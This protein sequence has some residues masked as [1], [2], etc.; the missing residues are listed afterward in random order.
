MQTAVLASIPVISKCS[1]RKWRLQQQKMLNLTS[2]IVPTL[3]VDMSSS[4]KL[5][6]L[7]PLKRKYCTTSM[8]KLQEVYLLSDCRV[9]YRQVQDRSER[10]LDGVLPGEI[11]DQVHEIQ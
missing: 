1:L 8:M 6:L 2:K 4:R 11:C 5:N 9:L 3:C 10:E 7:G